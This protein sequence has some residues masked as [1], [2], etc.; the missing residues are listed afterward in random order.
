MN[1]NVASLF[2]GIGGIDLGFEK[3]G[4]KTVWANDIDKYCEMTFNKNHTSTQLLIRDINQVNVSDIPYDVDVIAGG[5]P[6]QPFSI[7]GNRKGFDDDRGGLF[8]QII[9]LLEQYKEKSKLPKV[10]FL[11]NV[12]NLFKHDQGRTFYRMQKEL[13]KFGYIVTSK[14]M[15]TSEYGNLPQNRERLFIVAFLGEKY[16]QNFEWPEKIK[17]TNTI[18]KLINWDDEVNKK[19]YYDESS[20]I[21]PILKENITEKNVVYQYR[22]V[23]VRQNKAGIAPTLTANMGMGGHNVPIILDNMNRIRKLTPIECLMLQGFDRDFRLPEK[24]A[25]SRIYKQAGNSVSIPVIYR[26]ALNI[27]IALQKGDAKDGN[28]KV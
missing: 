26:I 11:E 22:R 5:F 17:L 25:D 12:K 2:A 14:I 21:Y 7:A 23:Y 4:F 20:L 16:I 6:C 19:Y 13:E 15:N 9:R 28:I 18:D 10:V 8:F 27:K 24:V 1:Y 3:A